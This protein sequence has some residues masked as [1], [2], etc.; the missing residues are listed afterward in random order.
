MRRGLATDDTIFNAMS[1]AMRLSTTPSEADQDVPYPIRRKRLLSGILTQSRYFG[2]QDEVDVFVSDAGKSDLHGLKIEQLEAL[3]SW[4]N[5]QID[6]QQNACDS[7][8]APPA[9]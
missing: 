4:L 5:A 6:A 2:L 7:A 3:S 9:R 1:E 8:L